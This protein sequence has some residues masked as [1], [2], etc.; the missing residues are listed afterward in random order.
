MSY[1]QPVTWYIDNNND[2]KP[3]LMGTPL[4]S[5]V[6]ATGV[7]AGGDPVLGNQINIAALA[8]KG[9]RQGALNVQITRALGQ[10]F[11]WDGNPDCAIKAIARNYSANTAGVGAERGIDIQA[12]NSG[13]NASWCNAASFNA[14]NDSGK[15]TYQ[16]QGVL[17]RLENYGTL[18]TEAVGLDVNMSIENDTGAPVK[19][20]IRVRNTDASG[21]TACN[22]VLSVSNTS[23][24]G[25][26][27]LLDLTGLT[28]AN[29]TLI[30]TSG[31]AAST[32]AG[33]I[34]ILDASG[35][36]AWVNIYSTSNE[37]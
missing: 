2:L 21:M 1:G 32:W 11:V 7:V 31:T 19:D 5:P 16:L 15:T 18:E 12:R 13:T 6:F 4:S 3:L 33:R 14:R 34:R 8:G 29:A 35:A 20:A 24:N 37:A 26:S 10:D 28:A 25:F 17:I 36:A 23:T 22:S 9:V 30:S 27:S